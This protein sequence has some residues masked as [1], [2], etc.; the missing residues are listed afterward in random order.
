MQVYLLIAAGG[1]LVI[2]Y[3]CYLVWMTLLKV[4]EGVSDGVKAIGAKNAGRRA[5]IAQE[6][7]LAFASAEQADIEAYRSQNPVRIVGIP[8]VE[9]YKR[10]FN[11]LDDFTAAANK[12]RPQFSGAL[13]GRF[14]TQF[15][16]HLFAFERPHPD[17]LSHT[18]PVKITITADELA[19]SGGLNMVKLYESANMPCTF[20]YEKPHCQLDVTAAP[21]FPNIQK[22]PRRAVK[23]LSRDNAEVDVSADYLRRAYENELNKVATL[24]DQATALFEE[25]DRKYSGAVEAFDIMN[26]Y[27]TNLK[28]KLKDAN[29]A[30]SE[31][32][33]EFKSAF[34]RDCEEATRPLR[35]TFRLYKD[36][37]PQG[38]KK[39]FVF[40]LSTLALPLPSNYQWDF[41]YD[42]NERLLQ[43]NQCVPSLS[44]ITIKRTDSNRPPAKRDAEAVLRRYVPSISLQLAH[45]VAVND[46]NDDVDTIAINCWSRFFEP[47]LGRLKDAFV[48]A[49]TVKKDEIQGMNLQRA[50][51]LEVFRALR[52]AF[53]YSL[54]DVVPIEPRI[55]LDKNDDRFVAGRDVLDGMAQGQNLAAMD[56][57]D[58]EHLIRELLSKE[59]ASD[60]SEVKIT[61]ASRDRGVDAIVFNSDPLH[62][63]KFVVQAKRYS[64]TVDVAAVRELYGTVLSEGA[65][66][67]ILV[68]TSHY[69]RDAYEW[70][71]NKPLT[72]IDGPN[73]LSLLSK[74]GYRFR[75]EDVRQ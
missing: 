22:P 2:G 55:R 21:V 48:A 75:I 7:A 62:G 15:P 56:W 23:L 10:V 67:G 52:G 19:M 9:A 29:A 40:A 25:F 11:A 13:D 60:N 20:P 39:H 12:F 42:E 18:E 34:E 66:R 58:F 46:L 45:M 41:F 47:S 51:A 3:A 73:L 57:Q 59:Y 6:K 8:N 65:N 43:V 63:G 53:V 1:I 32:H 16:S 38:I 44:D 26:L 33:A 61:R 50:D 49:L 69:G 27:L 24:N 71:A 70:A 54:Q 14:K 74:H 5:R 64:N 36:R 17:S 68:T 37:T 72:L 31:Q 30:I 35:T 4:T 28:L